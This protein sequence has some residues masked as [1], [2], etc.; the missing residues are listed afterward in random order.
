MAVETVTCRGQS[1][2]APAQVWA[3]ARRFCYPWHPMVASMRAEAGGAIRAFSVAGETTLYREQL[4]YLSDTDHRL[5]YRHL[6][7]IAGA[8]SY[9]AELRLELGDGGGT[10]LSWKAEIE[11][12]LPRAQEIAQG[13]RLVFEAGLAALADLAEQGGAAAQPPALPAAAPFAPVTI[14]TAPR[15]ALDATPAKGDALCLFLHGIGG[16]RD[17]WRDQIGIAG[18]YMRAAALD[19]RGYGDSTLGPAP[20]TVEA[21]C[22]DI[23][24]V[25]DQFGARRLVLCGL[26]YGAWIAA[27]FAQRHPDL[28]DGLILSGGCTGMSEASDAQRDGFRAAREGPLNAGQTPADFAPAVVDVIAGPDA[29]AEL[30]GRLRRSMAA[31]PARTYRDALHCFTNPP[32]RFDFSRFTMP[33]MLITGAH[34]RLA[35]P[36]EIRSVAE[37][38]HRAVTAPDIRFEVLE[39][40]GHVCNIEAPG[41]YNRLLA[42]FLAR[43]TA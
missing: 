36:D 15:L 38:M 32:E 19:L 17:N 33:V 24:A 7:G 39:Q 28:L 42:D 41:A 22:A 8:R 34:D 23:L 37:R 31:I 16:G 18:S 30:R 25:R 12:D 10:A 20:S 40:A 43:I 2:A 35:P 9:R 26:S 6:D 14:G 29:G 27:S 5:A 1:R 13:T 21:Y 11:A 4:T 3:I